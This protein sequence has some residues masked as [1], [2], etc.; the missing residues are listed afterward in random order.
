[1]LPPQVDKPAKRP[2]LLTG[3]QEVPQ[4]RGDPRQAT[5]LLVTPAHRPEL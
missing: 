5:G 4:A 2:H 1:M 3:T